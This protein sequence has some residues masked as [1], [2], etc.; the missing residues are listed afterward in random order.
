M[1]KYLLNLLHIHNH[2]KTIVSGYVSFNY[3]DVVSECKCGHRTIHEEHHS[4]IFPFPTVEPLGKKEIEYY[5]TPG[6]PVTVIHQIVM[7]SA[8]KFPA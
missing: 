2:N 6:N 7:D 5:L 3:R 8:R 1:I 4:N